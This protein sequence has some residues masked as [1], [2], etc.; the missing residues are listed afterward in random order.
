VKLPTLYSRTALG[1]IAEWT[2]EFESAD[3]R[4]HE[5]IVG[6]TI[7]TSAWTRCV[8]KNA[9][10]ANATTPEQQ[11]EREARAKW[12]KKTERGYHQDPADVDQ[13]QYFEPMLAHKWDKYGSKVEWPIA[14][15]PKLD[16]ERCVV[17][18]RGAFTREGKPVAII[19][20]IVRALQLLLAS[21]PHL[22]FDGEM[23]ADKFAHDF[24]ALMSLA[25]TSDP[26][27]EELAQ[28]EAELELWVF[29]VCLRDQPDMPFRERQA[30]LQ[31]LELPACVR[32]VPTFIVN[33]IEEF[34]KYYEE[35]LEAGLEGGMGRNLNSKYQHTRTRDLLKRKEFQDKEWP[36]DDV[37]PGRGKGAD[38][39]QKV[40]CRLEDN[41]TF[42]AGMTGT[43]E[44]CRKLLAEKERV[45]GQPATIKFQGYTK[46]GKPR[47][48]KFKGVRRT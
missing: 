20:H 45:K 41:R 26:T 9:G 8:G 5:G 47:F 29:D 17:H 30:F 10:R 15:Q 44:F 22:V 42:E 11:A 35:W 46:D 12:K 32:L 48:A 3:Y 18:A 19:P 23:Y 16:G 39:A 31:S 2:I 24:E 40:V 7:T 43:H 27:P 25:R 21:Y 37:L 38:M 1:Q 34:D 4:T 13:E 36:I 6:G 28:G 14:I 33:N